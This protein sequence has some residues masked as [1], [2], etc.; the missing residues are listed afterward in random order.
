[1][2]VGAVKSIQIVSDT[3]VSVEVTMRVKEEIK[4]FIK[5]RF[6]SEYRNRRFSR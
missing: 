1:M 2:D 6:E 3:S 4:S 5:K